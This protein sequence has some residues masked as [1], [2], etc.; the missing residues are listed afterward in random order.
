MITAT[1]M[2]NL[3]HIVAYLNVIAIPAP[4]FKS[5]A[6]QWAKETDLSA[7]NKS[8]S[9]SWIT[10]LSLLWEANILTGLSVENLE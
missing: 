6:T 3:V 5:D 2:H 4:I 7:E 1:G 9:I 8:P 10:P